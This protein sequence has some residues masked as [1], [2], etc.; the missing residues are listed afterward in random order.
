MQAFE[1]E[2]FYA[3]GKH[4]N[5]T[6]RKVE[7]ILIEVISAIEGWR[8]VHNRHFWMKRRWILSNDSLKG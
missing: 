3:S 5:L 1:L 7:K 2:D 4:M 6:K 8:L